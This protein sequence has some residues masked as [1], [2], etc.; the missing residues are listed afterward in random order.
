MKSN[1]KKYKPRHCEEY[2]LQDGTRQTIIKHSR[3]APKCKPLFKTMTFSKARLKDGNTI[4][5]L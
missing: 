1:I 5:V 4:T 3:P 2:L